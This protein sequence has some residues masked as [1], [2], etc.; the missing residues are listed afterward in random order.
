MIGS[1]PKKNLCRSVYITILIFAVFFSSCTSLSKPAKKFLNQ[2]NKFDYLPSNALFYVD[3]DVQKA[4][5]ILNTAIDNIFRQQKM[6][7]QQL[8]QNKQYSK[9]FLDK[10]NTILTGYYPK[11]KKQIIMGI[12]FGKSYPSSL[13]N[14]AL[15]SNTKWSK[16]TTESKLTYWKYAK[17]NLC[18]SV[19]GS[20]AFFSSGGGE[21]FSLENGSQAP[22][23]FTEL[24]KQSAVSI[25]FPDAQIIKN[26]L[27]SMDVPVN[28]P[29]TN[30]FVSLSQKNETWMLTFFFEATSSSQA[31]ALAAL[32]KIAKNQIK[33][34]KVR[35]P[36]AVKMINMMFSG[37]PEQ[38]DN[39]V[40]LHSPP[41]SMED[42][43]A[44]ITS[45]LPNLKL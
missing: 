37:V 19:H 6:S 9:M 13:V 7:E 20:K 26:I 2:K 22:S 44:M 15:S 16:I 18:L 14:M 4:R 3:I 5:P 39:K 41:L 34:L 23:G 30:F 12:A 24:N 21:P 35:D 40:F 36:A 8:K 10:T 28:L 33:N 11:N 1:I 27:D 42:I 43:T 25:L 38:N 32:F 17:N 45:Y 29:I 31:K